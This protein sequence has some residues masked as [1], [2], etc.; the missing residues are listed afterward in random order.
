MACFGCM[1]LYTTA[2]IVFSTVLVAAM[3]MTR[4]RAADRE[5]RLQTSFSDH[6]DLNSTLPMSPSTVVGLEVTQTSVDGEGVVRG[7]IEQS[8][9][10]QKKNTGETK[11]SRI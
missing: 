2:C 9:S 8:Y 3:H 10:C 7:L 5:S 6:E 1:V 4:R 11:K